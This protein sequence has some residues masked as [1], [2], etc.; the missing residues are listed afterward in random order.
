M[1]ELTAPDGSGQQRSPEASCITFSMLVDEARIRDLIGE[2]L[3]ERLGAVE[4]RLDGLTDLCADRVAPNQTVPALLTERELAGL[5]SVHP[6]T[7]RRL[8]CNRDIPS[9]VYVGGSKRWRL[10]EIEEWMTD[11]KGRRQ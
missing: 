6:R 3:A 2:L 4:R 1:K 7:I 10:Q 5:L 8:E 9:S 11:L